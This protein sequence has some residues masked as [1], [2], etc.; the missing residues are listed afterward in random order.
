MLQRTVFFYLGLH[1]VLRGVD[2]QHSLVPCQLIRFPVDP[3]KYSEDVYYEYTEYISKK[4][5]N[6]VLKMSM[7]VT[8]LSTSGS[9]RCR[10]FA[11]FV[12]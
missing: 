12:L 2:E 11:G 10:S 9:D 5:I 7:L 4:I 8:S 3:S 1:F 6:T